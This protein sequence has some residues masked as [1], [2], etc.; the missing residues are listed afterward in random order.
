MSSE[1]EQSIRAFEQKYAGKLRAWA[2]FVDPEEL[3]ELIETIKVMDKTSNAITDQFETRKEPLYVDTWKPLLENLKG[4]LPNIENHV[5]AIRSGIRQNMG[6]LGKGQR[7][8]VGYRT[9]TK[10]KNSIFERDA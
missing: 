9:S 4:L 8:L 7:G 3:D 10:P 5:L 2:G 1:L 6:A